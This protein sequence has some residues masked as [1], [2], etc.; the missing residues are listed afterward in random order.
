MIFT[1]K[2]YNE[3]R[4]LRQRHGLKLKGWFLAEDVGQSRD[5]A[6]TLGFTK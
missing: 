6:G 2:E 3:V 1:K 5:D 4:A